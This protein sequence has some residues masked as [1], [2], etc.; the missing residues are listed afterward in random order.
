MA[1]TRHFPVPPS[2]V[3]PETRA[4]KKRPPVQT[5]P[6]KPPPKPKDPNEQIKDSITSWCNELEKKQFQ[7]GKTGMGRDVQIFDPESRQMMA[8]LSMLVQLV[9]NNEIKASE[10]NK[11]PFKINPRDCRIQFKKILRR[12]REGAK[13]T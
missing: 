6:P 11:L 13:L 1:D 10:C 3:N 4:L 9:P 8:V 12:R 7:G 2:S 5:S